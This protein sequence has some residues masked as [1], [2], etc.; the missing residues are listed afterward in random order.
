MSQSNLNSIVRAILY[1]LIFIL[2]SPVMREYKISIK[3]DGSVV[4]CLEFVKFPQL[5]PVGRSMGIWHRTRWGLSVR[6]DRAIETRLWNIP[7]PNA[8]LLAVEISCPLVK[9]FD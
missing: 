8:R 2:A 4:D 9:L 1:L 3:P 5:C 7:S 6:I